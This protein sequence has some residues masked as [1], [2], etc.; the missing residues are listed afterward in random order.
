MHSAAGLQQLVNNIYVALRQ[1]C[2]DGF[3]HVQPVQRTLPIQPTLA[4]DDVASIINDGRGVGRMR[5][6]DTRLACSTF[7]DVVA[8]PVILLLVKY[9]LAAADRIVTI[10]IGVSWIRVVRTGGGFLEDVGDLAAGASKA[11]VKVAVTPHAVRD[12]RYL[13][14]QS[15]LISERK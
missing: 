8:I 13:R 9:L 7:H 4:C 2:S 12:L 14:R 11:S 10:E 5:Q 6:C 1:R 15:I 3:V